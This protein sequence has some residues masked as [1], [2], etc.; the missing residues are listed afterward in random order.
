M[1]EEPSEER[2]G[3]GHRDRPLSDSWAWNRPRGR[4]RHGARGISPYAVGPTWRI[5]TLA[6]VA[7]VCVGAFMIF[8]DGSYFPQEY[9][10]AKPW[11]AGAAL[12]VGLVL[13]FATT[14]SER[15]PE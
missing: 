13:V 6:G 4:L 12:I 1:V 7:L 11:I 3:P 5:P 14:R 10:A 2:T 9:R 8:G 15:G